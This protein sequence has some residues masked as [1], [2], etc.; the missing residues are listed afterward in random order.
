MFPR[1]WH[2]FYMYAVVMGISRVLN[3]NHYV[4]DVIAGAMFGTIV[5]L[6]LYQT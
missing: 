1:Y 6:L 2:Y 3:W 5:T 4:S